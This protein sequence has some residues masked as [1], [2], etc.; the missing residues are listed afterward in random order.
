MVVRQDRGNVEKV[1]ESTKSKGVAKAEPIGNGACKEG[2]NSKGAVEGDIGFVDIVRVN[3]T[4]C[5]KA[6]NSIEHAR[7]KEADQ[8]DQDKLCYR[9][10]KPGGIETAN[11]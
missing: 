2:H 7:A 5:T 10:C 9:R 4:T 3:K 11:F 1:A 6:T 8:R